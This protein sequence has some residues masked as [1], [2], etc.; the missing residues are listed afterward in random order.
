MQRGAAW[1]AVGA[2]AGSVAGLAEGV[3]TCASSS[4]P[5]MV[6]VFESE[7][8]AKAPVALCPRPCVRPRA[9]APPPSARLRL[10]SV[11][12]RLTSAKVEGSLRA[13]ERCPRPASSRWPA[14]APPS[15]RRRGRPPSASGPRW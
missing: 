10:I 4:A 7:L 14:K 11:S 6:L 13:L 15:G 2:P 9:L 8:V 12:R 3:Q 1:A 5:S